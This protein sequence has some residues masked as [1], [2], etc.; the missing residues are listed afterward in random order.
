MKDRYKTRYLKPMKKREAIAAVLESAYLEGY[1][2][3]QIV[4]YFKQELS[5]FY[6]RVNVKKLKVKK[7]LMR[8]EKIF[9]L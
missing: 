6:R 2:P 1:S 9:E 7:T 4:S 8:C 3:K 5:F